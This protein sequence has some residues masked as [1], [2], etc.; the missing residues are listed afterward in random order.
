[1]K[2]GQYIVHVC[3]NRNNGLRT[4]DLC[5]G[6]ITYRYSAMLETI[7]SRVKGKGQ[8]SETSKTR[9]TLNKQVSTTITRVIH[10]PLMHEVQYF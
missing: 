1:M 7:V 3:T 10:V 5:S 9:E 2:V 8:I 6:V 4:D